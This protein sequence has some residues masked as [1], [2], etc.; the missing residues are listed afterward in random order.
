MTDTSPSYY[1]IKKRVSDMLYRLFEGQKGTHSDVL[2]KAKQ[3][4]GIVLPVSD[5]YSQ[6]ELDDIVRE[7]VEMYEIEVGVKTYAP[8]VIAKDKQSK[9]WL[10]KVK[11]FIQHAYFDRYKLYLSKE[12][13]AQKSID[14]IES[15]C[16][17]TLSYCANPKCAAQR[18]QKRGLVM[19]DVQSGKTANYL[20]LI[21]M[22]FDYGYKIIVLL[23]GTTKSLRIQTQKRMDKGVIGAKSDSIGNEIDYIGVGFD[24]Q[25]HYAVP[26]TNQTNDFA[27]F[28]QRN[29]NSAIGDYNK[30]VVLVVKKVKSILESVGSRLQAVLNEKG[31]DSKSILII[32][33]EADNASV[34]TATPAN[35]PTAINRCIRAIY[36][37]FPIASYV[38]YT[39]TPFANIFINPRD[40]QKDNLDLFPADF[41]VQL[42]PPDYYFGGRKVFPNDGEAIP[43]C[44]RLIYEGEP[45]YLP[46]IHK[47][48]ACFDC[49]SD[50]LI[51]AINSFLID[52][53]I[54]TL[55]G[56]SKKHRTMM[57][58]ITR[59]NDVQVKIQERVIEYIDRLRETIEQLENAS[60]EMFIRN[61]RMKSL[62]DLYQSGFFNPIKNGD[63]AL[64]QVPVSWSEI[65]HGLYEE[66]KLMLVVVINSRNGKMSRH[67]DSGVNRRFDYEEYN[68]TGARIIAIGGMVLSRGLTL[69]GLMVSYYSRNATTYDTLLQMCRWFG[70]RPNYEDLCRIY[71]SQE[72]V[73]HFDAVLDAADDLR[74]QFAEMERQGKTPKDF[75]LMI[76]ESPDTLETTML[77]TSRNKMRGTEDIIYHLNYGGVYADTSKLLKDAAINDHNSRVFDQLYDNTQFAW[78]LEHNRYWASNVPKSSVAAMISNLKIPYANKKF[79]TQGLS[80]YIASSDIFPIWDVVIAT[81]ERREGHEFKGIERLYTVKRSFHV[82]CDNDPYIR[83]GGHNNRVMEP[84]ILNVGLWLSRADADSILKAK[85]AVANDD[86]QYNE[87]TAKDYLKRRERPILVIYPIDLATEITDVEKGMFSEYD[88]NEMERIKKSIKASIGENIPLL[89]FAIAF[90]ERESKVVVTY[91]ANRIKLDEL[92][93]NAEVDDDDEGAD[94]N[95]D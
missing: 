92:T 42:N 44:L 21:N 3:L 10:S 40:E 83:I 34:N 9:Y 62:Y 23:A 39:A 68:G 64:E 89:A 87:L 60:T 94:E 1:A 15:T 71:L 37:K 38:G 2:K 86:R 24:T 4:M 72:N 6:A 50:S 5:S 27:R 48:E 85:R 75:G 58:N 13:F 66:I 65:Q 95:D 29:L 26:F 84:G 54:R 43:R 80:E 90:P 12:G 57:I 17:L 25:E 22:A 88:W 51:E 41:I 32:D 33:D 76:K 77:I 69:E 35:T 79:D 73:D 70:Y 53:V 81:G 28:M 59:F 78:D 30:P 74:E 11:Q 45:G 14:N 82:N 16:E 8:N 63:P 56:Q 91:R 93:A 49:L 52:N 55:R 46:V 47:K 61:A 31:L 7:S 20:G 36:N 19:G 18:D 67:D